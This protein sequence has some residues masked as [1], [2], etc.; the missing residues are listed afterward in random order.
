MTATYEKIATTTLS[1]NAAS[2]TFSSISQNFTD[3]IIIVTPKLVSGTA[4]VLFQ[5]NGDTGTN[6][7]L[8]RM[9]ADGSVTGS[10]KPAPTSFGQLSWWGYAGST[11]GQVI[12]ASLNNYS[13]NTTYKTM[14]SRN[15]NANYG[16]GL[17]ACMWRNTAA[18]TSILI[19]SDTANFDTG[20]TFTLYGIKAE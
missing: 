20:S 14:L 3:L 11:F 10:S 19:Y 8:L 18:V 17:N 13:N 9:G 4:Q 15:D 2:V 6:Y 12:T 7:S 1:S 16:V 5:L